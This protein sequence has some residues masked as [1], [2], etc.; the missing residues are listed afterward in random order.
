MSDQGFPMIYLP[1]KIIEE[2]IKRGY[3]YDIESLVIDSIIEKL[4]MSLKEST[5]N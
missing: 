2:A 1:R 5:Y 4:R 3:D